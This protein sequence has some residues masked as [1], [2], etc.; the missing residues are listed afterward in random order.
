MGDYVRPVRDNG[1]SPT[2]CDSNLHF[3]GQIGVWTFWASRCAFI[4][5]GTVFQPAIRIIDYL[6]RDYTA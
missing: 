1:I 4:E 6:G 2:V 3:Q 5:G